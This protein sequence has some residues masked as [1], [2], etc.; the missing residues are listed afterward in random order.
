M[1][2][3]WFLFTLIFSLT[4]YVT[5]SYADDA[6]TVFT[7]TTNAFLDEGALPVLYTCDDKDLSPQLSWTNAPAKTQ[8]YALIIEDPVAK[9]DK[10]YHW[11][12]YD[13]PANVSELTEG[14]AKLPAGALAGKNSDGKT[15]Y[16]GPCP[17]KGSVNSYILTLFALD[18]KLALPE[19]SEGDAVKKALAGHTLGKSKITMVYSR[20]P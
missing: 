10:K 15:T 4:L 5:D 1:R 7:L 14:V 17:P 9:L 12:V 13:I 6:P 19:G 18:Q 3:S 8:A 20:W 2:F 11:V 16:L